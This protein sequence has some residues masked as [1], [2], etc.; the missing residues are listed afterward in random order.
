MAKPLTH[1]AYRELAL[2]AYRLWDK[3]GRPIGSPEVDWFG[4]SW[5]SQ[6]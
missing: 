4:P 1:S 5:N 2:Y 6:L 3:R